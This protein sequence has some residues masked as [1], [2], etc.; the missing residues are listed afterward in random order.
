[1]DL[2]I[3]LAEDLPLTRDLYRLPGA[4]GLT[5]EQRVLE[6]QFVHLPPAE[7]TVGGLWAEIALDGMVLFERGIRVSQRLA[8]IRH[9]IAEGRLVRRTVHGQPYW[10][11]N[12]AA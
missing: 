2:L 4:D 6:P 5:W 12:E 1:V 8:R 9:D 11:I 7:V 10:T 3:V